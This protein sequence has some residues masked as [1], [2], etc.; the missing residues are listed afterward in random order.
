MLDD[1]DDH[2]DEKNKEN[3]PEHK[4]LPSNRKQQQIIFCNNFLTGIHRMTNAGFY[5]VIPYH[6]LNTPEL[7]WTSDDLAII[8]ASLTMG[9][10]IGSQSQP[11][12]ALLTSSEKKSLF[13]GHLSQ[14]ICGIIG[15][16]CL[17]S[18]IGFNYPLFVFGCLLL[19]YNC[20]C[21][22][23]QSYKK[24]ISHGNTEIALKI[25]KNIGNLMI[26]LNIVYALTLPRIFD[27]FGYKI[28]CIVPF[29]FQCIGLCVLFY[30]WYQINKLVKIRAV[31][32]V[33]MRKQE[34][35]EKAKDKIMK[36]VKSNNRNELGELTQQAAADRVTIPLWKLLSPCMYLTFFQSFS[37]AFSYNSY[38]IAYPI[39]FDLEWNISSSVG[40][41]LIAGGNVFAFILLNVML[42]CSDKCVL[43]QYPF[44]II[45]PITLFIIGNLM[46]VIVYEPFIAYSFHMSVLSIL[47]VAYGAE[48]VARIYLCGPNAFHK[49]TSINGF[50]LS[51]GYFTGASVTPF[52]FKIH[53]RLPFLVL[54]V[55]NTLV[56]V[57]M[58]VVFFRRK[59]HLSTFYDDVNVSNY[60][61]HEIRFYERIEK[62]T[63][64]RYDLIIDPNVR[65][66]AHRIRRRNI[67]SSAMLL[68][69]MMSAEYIRDTLIAMENIQ[70]IR[71]E[72]FEKE[73]E[74]SVVLS[75]EEPDVVLAIHP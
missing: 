42:R 67:G 58:L 64:R 43:F 25:M 29:S 65:N 74:K 71:D 16:A 4:A 23:V 75:M 15:W 8:Y 63:E 38:W 40:G 18:I 31:V 24:I 10:I 36:I 72:K 69:P 66:I 34:I 13:I 70:E 26:I 73:S 37:S 2:S 27:E 20:N 39:I 17:S 33:L 32:E 22:I 49:V 30:E 51:V 35:A 28:F 41:Y 3:A 6:V 61:E 46:Y 9:V 1:P 68:D 56:I 53:Q 12:A 11:M 50:I 52:L 45:V 62:S 54:A 19:G 60:L 55:V 57:V 5:Y 14:L 44:N 7:G 48:M 59:D 21:T 47:R